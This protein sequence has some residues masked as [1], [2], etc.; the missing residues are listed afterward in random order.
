MPLFIN[1]PKGSKSNLE[2][3][4]EKEPTS[5][6]ETA[7]NLHDLQK[8]DAN[9]APSEGVPQV[10]AAEHSI[11]L[12]EHADGSAVA[13][14]ALR[15]C[16]VQHLV[17]SASESTFMTISEVAELLGTCDKTVHRW[18]ALGKLEAYKP[19]RHWK[20]P[21]RAVVALLDRSSSTAKSLAVAQCPLESN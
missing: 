4:A 10:V 12:P 9:I 17:E 1:R 3:T 7:L 19:G 20:I 14:L 8:A 18:I 2:P 11:S 13:G 6:D 21:K 5:V 15:Q 16:D